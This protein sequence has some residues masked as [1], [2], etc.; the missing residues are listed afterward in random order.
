MAKHVWT[1][2]C[3]RAIVNQ[4]DNSLSLIDQI[5]GIGVPTPPPPPPD[6]PNALPAIP[7]GF[8]ITSLWRRSDP[9]RPERVNSRCKILAPDGTNLIDTQLELVLDDPY[10]T[11]RGF[12]QLPL[13]PLRGP[14]TYQFVMYLG[15]GK[16]WKKVTSV[17]LTVQYLEPQAV[18]AAAGKPEA[19]AAAARRR[20]AK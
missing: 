12:M 10:Q 20:K 7:V 16:V 15:S 19:H 4:A 18:D 3:R 14:G 6:N 11:I 1:I 17:P 2:V 13:L 8:Y 9:N 5:D